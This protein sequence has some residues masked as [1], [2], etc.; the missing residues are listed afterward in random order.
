MRRKYGYMLYIKSGSGCSKP[1]AY[2]R[3]GNRNLP[4]VLSIIVAFSVAALSHAAAASLFQSSARGAFDLSYSAGRVMLS[5]DVTQPANDDK[6][7]FSIAITLPA[8][9]R[10]GY[11]DG[12]GYSSRQMRWDAASSRASVT[13]PYGTHQLL[14]GWVGSGELPPDNV[15]IPVYLN[16]HQV[17]EMKATF[18]L[19]SMLAS[20]KFSLDEM[21]RYRVRI[22]LNDDIDRDAVLLSVGQTSNARWSKA[23]NTLAGRGPVFA[24]AASTISL[25]VQAP[26]LM[27]S[28]VR[29]VSF[30]LASRPARATVVNDV[31]TD[32]YIVEAEHYSENGGG[33]S[34]LV[35]PGSH[36]DTHGGSCVYS[37]KGDGTWL[38]WDFT[39][40]EDGEYDLYTRISTGEP[41][42]SRSIR[43]K[44][45]SNPTLTLVQ[46]PGTGGWGHAAGEW[47]VMRITGGDGTPSLKLK[48]GIQT[49]RVTGIM[50]TDMNIDYLM[51]IPAK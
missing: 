50:D 19:D 21:G 36:Y 46:F 34:F 2:Y 20:G 17:G 4:C 26:N 49:V 15:T 45:Q 40:P 33:N 14:I 5:Y 22:H 3:S 47:Q 37:F 35:T 48:A 30:E 25:R 10:W 32:G 38:Q 28:P 31:P 18:T 44:G 16:G 1:M 11:L 12:A 8:Q 7:E 24:A 39:V 42:V 9:T 6:D 23:S 27:E 41:T 13:V 29:A 51:L 43:I